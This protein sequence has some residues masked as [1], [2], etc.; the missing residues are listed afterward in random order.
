MV[1]LNEQQYFKG[2][3]HHARA[4]A[5]DLRGFIEVEAH[6]L[7]MLEQP[8]PKAET[9]VLADSHGDHPRSEEQG[10][11]NHVDAGQRRKN[12][13]EE[14]PTIGTAGVGKDAIDQ[15]LETIRKR[16]IGQRQ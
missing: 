8:A 11:T 5:A 9:D 1:L 15:E 4:E 3:V 6:L 14:L 16:Q 10:V 7:Q 2:I 12:P 13:P